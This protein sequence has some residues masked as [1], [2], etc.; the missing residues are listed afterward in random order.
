MKSVIIYWALHSKVT[1]QS[2]LEHP[3]LMFNISHGSLILG[4]G[5]YPSKDPWGVPF[6][7]QHDPIRYQLAGKFFTDGQRNFRGILDGIQSDQDYLRLL[8]NLQTGPSR[9][10]C[11]FYCKRVQWVSNKMPIGGINHPDNL[12]TVF[13]D[14]DKDPSLWWSSVILFCLHPEG[15]NFKL[16]GFFAMRIKDTGSN[17]GSQHL[18]AAQDPI[19]CKLPSN[20][21]PITAF[22]GGWICPWK[23]LSM[24]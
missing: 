5:R 21:W 7:D 11:C 20:T 13:G 18:R 19:T 2:L 16:K 3:F 15:M 12:Y 1:F 22:G 9:Q 17:F 23:F 4:D 10:L 24:S 6:S 8:F 14:E